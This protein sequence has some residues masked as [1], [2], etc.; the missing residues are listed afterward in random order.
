VKRHIR[1]ALIVTSTLLPLQSATLERLSL[2]DLIVKS[3]AIVRATVSESW[4]AF[5]GREIQTH[6]KIQVSEQFKG[7]AQKTI[8]IIAP[9]GTVGTLH[10]TVPGSPVLNRGDEFVFF[11]WTSKAGVTWITGLTQGLFALPGGSESDPVAK[12]AAN[13]ELMLDQA[14][15]HPVKDSAVSMKLSDL[16]SRIAAKLGQ[17]GAR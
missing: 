12:R 16:R 5:S 4:A 14:T 8:E 11:L 15:G 13:R 17:G 10:Q 2:D 1:I 6:Y 3:T 7:T 9:G